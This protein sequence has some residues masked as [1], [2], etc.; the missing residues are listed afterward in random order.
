MNTN[1]SASSSEWEERAR[2]I[3]GELERTAGG[4]D[5]RGRD[6]ALYNL[7][8]MTVEMNMV[9]RPVFPK[10][11]GLPSDLDLYSLIR[12]H[13][14]GRRMSANEQSDFESLQAWRA[15]VL[16]TEGENT[17]SLVVLLY[18]LAVLERL[19]PRGDLIRTLRA[20]LK[21]AWRIDVELDLPG[22][23]PSE[24]DSLGIDRM[25]MWLARERDVIPSWLLNGSEPPRHLFFEQAKSKASD[26][27][28]FNPGD[29]GAD[30]DDD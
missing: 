10:P 13:R 17:G 5:P 23:L 15:S 22:P 19:E 9:R 27:A 18:A 1:D 26:P 8:R 4:R 7:A 24:G 30:D 3:V 2:R 28:S 6:I 29:F 12:K 20:H 16:A 21:S 14:S 11:P 25:A